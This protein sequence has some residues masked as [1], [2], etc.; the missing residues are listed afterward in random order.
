[1]LATWYKRT[2]PL[3]H[4]KKWLYWPWGEYRVLRDAKAVI[5]ASEQ[6]KLDAR[7]SFWLYRANELVVPFG[8]PAPGTESGFQKSAFLG[9]FPELAQARIALFLGRIHPI[10]GCDELIRAFASA[11]GKNPNWRLVIA[12]PDQVGLKPRLM[13][14]ASEAGIAQRVTWTG[15]LDDDM[16]EGAFRSAEVFVL[17][18]HHESFGMVVAEAL[19][20]GLPV[21]ISDKVNIWREVVAD[22]AGFASNDDTDS[23]AKLLQRWAALSKDDRKTMS[24]S[25]SKCFS[26]RFEIKNAAQHLQRSLG[27]VLEG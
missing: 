16:K 3:K 9:R 4:A 13:R 11:L 14:L 7:R 26:K 8:V 25:A 6:E 19:S 22:G 21:L 18:S 17:P 5:F 20:R 24:D 27:A 15:M 1:M 10:K 23:A 2:Y 12:G